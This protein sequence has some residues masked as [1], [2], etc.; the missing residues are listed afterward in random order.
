MWRVRRREDRD[1]PREGQ[2]LQVKDE[3][4]GGK[5][6]REEGKVWLFTSSHEGTGW[7]EG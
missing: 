2:Q 3:E 4:G 5:G 7:V 6:G 1:W